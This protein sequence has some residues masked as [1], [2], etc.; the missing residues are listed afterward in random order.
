MNTITDLPSSD[1]NS[2]I[3]NSTF[4]TP[5]PSTTSCFKTQVVPSEE[6]FKEV[7]NEKNKRILGESSV[8]NKYQPDNDVQQQQ[9][10]SLNVFEFQPRHHRPPMINNKSKI[11]DNSS[12]VSNIHSTSSG[13][14]VRG[15]KSPCR[16]SSKQHDTSSRYKNPSS[17]E[18]PI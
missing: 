8:T 1:S 15:G 7:N 14:N 3:N 13:S 16:S 12:N 10:N 17:F 18:T 6:V 11:N 4:G 9:T 2:S 5:R